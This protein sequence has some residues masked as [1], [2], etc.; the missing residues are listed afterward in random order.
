MPITYEFLYD[1]KF[2]WHS[3]IISINGIIISSI[4]D[5]TP[6]EAVNKFIEL[7]KQHEDELAITATKRE[8]KIQ[9]N[10]K[11]PY[12]QAKDWPEFDQFEELKNKLLKQAGVE[13]P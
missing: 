5:Q 8:E 13:D 2:K 3:H 11:Q 1:E 12:G 10:I 6:I 9:W 4:T 7:C